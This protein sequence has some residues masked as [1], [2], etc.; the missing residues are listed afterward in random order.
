[1]LGKL[2]WLFMATGLAIILSAMAVPVLWLILR[3]VG[4]LPVLIRMVNN[5]Q[6][7]IQG[8]GLI[9]GLLVGSLAM[10]LLGRSQGRIDGWA[11]GFGALGGAV[12]GLAS[13]LMFF[14]IVAIL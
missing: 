10:V 11:V 1:M 3:V 12:G 5:I 2:F 14:P 6:F 8:G 9:F 7:L 13:S 4:L